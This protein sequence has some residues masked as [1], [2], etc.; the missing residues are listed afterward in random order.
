MNLVFAILGLFLAAMGLWGV[1]STL[2][3]KQQ[4][5]AVCVD[6]V[7]ISS[8]GM[9]TYAAVFAYTY[10]GVEY[11][12]PSFQSFPRQRLQKRFRLQETYPVYIDP[13]NPARVAVDRTPQIIQWLLM[14]LGVLM[15]V[16]G[17][18]G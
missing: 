17:L 10:Q 1:L 2:R 5:E 15:V 8:Q 14:L 18:R 3:C 16:M 13:Q 7:A 12:Q 4:I 11:R 6:S 9:K